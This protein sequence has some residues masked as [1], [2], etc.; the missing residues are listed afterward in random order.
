MYHLTHLRGK[1]NLEFSK[2]SIIFEFSNKKLVQIKFQIGNS[3]S[4]RTQ[5]INFSN[6]LHFSKKFQMVTFDL[7][8]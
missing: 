6:Y 4:A 3:A 5:K 7:Y 8:I 1:V 2:T